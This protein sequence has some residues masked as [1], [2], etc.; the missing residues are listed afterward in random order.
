MPE[1]RLK[2][3]KI[4]P[5]PTPKEEEKQESASNF[6]QNDSKYLKNT[7]S[8]EE[9]A[10]YSSGKTT[11]LLP[12]CPGKETKTKEQWAKPEFYKENFPQITKEELCDSDPDDRKTAVSFDKDF[13]K[14]HTVKETMP[15]V[16]L[17]SL[18]TISLAK[19]ESFY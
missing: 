6:V 17:D 18:S 5:K 12:K 7:K 9:M 15:E 14:V 2:P 10:C 8:N 11:G 16:I 19:D 3:P 13:A 1:K 4:T